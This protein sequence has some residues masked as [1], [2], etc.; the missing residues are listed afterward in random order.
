MNPE[1]L[2]RM[3]LGVAHNFR[4]PG[5]GRH[6]RRAAHEALFHALGGG[7]VGG[8][9]HAGVVTVDDEQLVGCFV[10]EPL[11]QRGLVGSV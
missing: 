5:A 3:A 6:D 8:M 1:V 2:L 11:G 7:K 9:T 10:S 4:K